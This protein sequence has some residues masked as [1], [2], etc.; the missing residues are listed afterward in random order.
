[1]SALTLGQA[2]IG[3]RDGDYLELANQWEHIIITRD[4]G[5]EYVVTG[6]DKAET[7][8]TVGAAITCAMKRLAMYQ[9]GRA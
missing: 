6:S 1:M 4:S 3:Q 9:D 5:T 7:F 2:A 8:R